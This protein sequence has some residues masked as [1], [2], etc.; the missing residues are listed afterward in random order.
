MLL[1][2]KADGV[3]TVT[4]N[5]PEAM[6]AMSKALRADLA[7]AF[8]DLGADPDV[9]VAILTGAGTRAF[10]AGLDLKELGTDPLGM[11][12][13]NATGR[14]AN[15]VR[16]VLHC[17]KPVIAAVN[18]VAI[19][20]GF[21]L[22]LACDVILAS[23]NARFADTHGRVGITPG[24]GLSQRLSR[25]IGVYRAKELSLTGN[26]LD[27]QTACDW[28]L[29]N[30]VVAPEDLMPAALKLAHEMAGI[31]ADMLVMY[32]SMIDD[33]YA[34]P[35]GEG[36]ALEHERS[37][38]WNAKVTPEIVEANRQAVLARGRRQ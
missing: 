13:A 22:A 10:T 15:P 12:A 18:G 30:R 6:N 36:M 35:F 17:K 37:T 11:G 33:G 9:R 3:A 27:A 26:F 8:D 4:L 23:T 5:R 16:A 7:A 32:K 19:T 21:E 2:D 38:A 20:G 25:V 24:W 31:P 1:I 14:D 28:G 34:L 29:V